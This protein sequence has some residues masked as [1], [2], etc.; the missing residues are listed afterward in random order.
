MMSF[1]V[2]G[3]YYF[4]L[5]DCLFN[6]SKIFLFIVLTKINVFSNYES[7]SHVILL[8]VFNYFISK[9]TMQIKNTQKVKINLIFIKKKSANTKIERYFVLF[10]INLFIFTLYFRQHI[11]TNYLTVCNITVNLKRISEMSM[12]L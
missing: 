11:C 12:L 9:Y 1:T 4:K 6:L 2:V 3:P 7:F 8:N 5:T 10:K